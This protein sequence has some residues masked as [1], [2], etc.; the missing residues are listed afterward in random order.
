MTI[1]DAILKHKQSFND[2]S[3]LANSDLK[4][5]EIRMNLIDACPWTSGDSK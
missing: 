4:K 3:Q 2:M 1:I 5:N